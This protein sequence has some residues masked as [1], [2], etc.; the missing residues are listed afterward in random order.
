[1]T[2]NKTEHFFSNLFHRDE[3][4]E[5]I[6]QL[7]NMAMEKLLKTTSTEPAPGLAVGQSLDSSPSK[8]SIG[9]DLLSKPLKQSFENQ[10]RNKEFQYLFNLP[11]S[12]F[13][14]DEIEA[15]V[16]IGGG[17]VT[18]QGKL[19]LS[20]TFL[21]FQS[22]EK[23]SCQLALPFFA[24]MRVERI[25]SIFASVSITARHQL[26]LLFQFHSEKAASDA[27]CDSLK[28]C[29]QKHV[30]LMKLLKPFLSTCASEEIL[31]GK[32]VTVGVL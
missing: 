4:F 24:I 32:D 8:P 20:S 22:L 6:E 29:L 26:K 18:T 16:T 31:A 30:G 1:M 23:Y 27:F 21:C 3:T 9:G 11:I 5:L 2:R 10:K 13:V 14:L 7:T 19:Y 12:E 28:S 25:N 17:K 15:T